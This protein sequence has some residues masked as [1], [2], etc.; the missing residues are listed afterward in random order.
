M[1]YCT[2]LKCLVAKAIFKSKGCNLN[3]SYFVVSFTINLINLTHRHIILTGFYFIVP[4]KNDSNAIEME[5]TRVHP[6][7]RYAYRSGKCQRPCPP[8]SSSIA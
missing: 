5:H 2:N 8:S 1:Y 3:S 6:S 7:R 4:L